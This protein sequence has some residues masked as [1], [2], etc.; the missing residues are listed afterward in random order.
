MIAWL[1]GLLLR[2]RDREMI[3][4]DL[5]EERGLLAATLPAR[6]AAR[7]YRRQMLR[8]IPPV[9]WANVRRG[10]WMKTLGAAIAGYLVA[11]ILIVASDAAIGTI[12]TRWLMALASLTVGALV[13]ALGGYLASAMRPCAAM[14]LS[15]LVGALSILNLFLP[16]GE[17]TW[18]KVGLV[19][20]GPAASLAGGRIRIRRREH[21]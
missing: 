9:M 7:W 17:E 19:L 13:M 5:V 10:I 2:Q 16:T 1:F 15:V 8:S 12:G 21:S 6:Q 20:V 14:V 18:Y 11:A 4:G 3:L